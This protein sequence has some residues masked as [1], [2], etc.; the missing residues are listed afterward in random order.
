MKSSELRKW[1]IEQG[2][3]FEKAKG[4][5]FKVYLG[6]KMTIFPFHGAKEMATGTVNKILKDLGLK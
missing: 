5:H 3:R 4:S 6:D 1:L 2:A